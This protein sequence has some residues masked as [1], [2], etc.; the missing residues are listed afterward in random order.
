MRSN[1]KEY[2]MWAILLLVGSILLFGIACDASDGKSRKALW[3]QVAQAEAD[4]LPETAAALLGQIYTGA[5]RDGADIEA[6][7]ALVKKILMESVTAGN[8]P[9][10]K[11]RRLREAIPQ[12]PERIQP[13]LRVIL[14]QWFNHYYQRNRY[15]FLNRDATANLDE[16]DFTTWDLPRLFR[17]MDAL[18]QSVLADEERLLRIPTADFRKFLE[19]GNMP[20]ALRPTLFD[21]VA[22]QAIAFYTSKD[23]FR[24]KPQDAFEISADSDALAPAA[25][26]VRW[27]PATTDTESPLFKA[28]NF[29]SASCASMPGRRSIGPVRRRPAPA[30]LGA[31]RGRGRG[32]FRALHGTTEGAGELGRRRQHGRPGPLLLGAGT[33]R[34]GGAHGG[35]GRRRGGAPKPPKSV[36]GASAAA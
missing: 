25:A 24:P 18:Y 26:F 8:H 14:A 21:F 32:G 2:S 1:T 34:A 29:I 10:E 19:P 11:V 16:Q 5:C 36:G 17:E 27:Q 31:Q 7:R 20:D 22:D 30:A 4:G 3:E 23:T 12:A 33:A 15:R 28:L 13:L 9:E 6:L 35:P